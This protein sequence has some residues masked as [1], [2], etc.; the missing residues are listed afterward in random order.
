MIQ[1]DHINLQY[2]SKILFRDLSWHIP[3]GHKVILSGKSGIGKTSLMHLVLGYLPVPS[4]TVTVNGQ[5]VT[6]KTIWAIRKQ[7][8][9]V[10][11]DVSLPAVRAMD[12]IHTVFDY[13]ANQ[14]IGLDTMKMH[15]LRE[16]LELEER[17]LNKNTKDLSGG[18]RQRLGLL[19]AMLLRRDIF[20]L[21]EPTSALDADLKKKVVDYVM[22]Q[23]AWTA[24]IITH[25]AV[26][27]DHPQTRI[28]DLKE[29]TWTP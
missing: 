20:L 12:W 4:G 18:E 29:G 6:A 11:Q 19:V 5:A 16:Y 23:S 27:L 24:L 1:F 7:I 8:A 25:D 22:Q 26:W 3:K 14:A 21:D 9:Y 10:D 2:D 17:D 15:H 28:F 13:R